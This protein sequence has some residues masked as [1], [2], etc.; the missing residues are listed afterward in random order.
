MVNGP[1]VL[2]ATLLLLV[3]T[4][5]VSSAS[6]GAATYTYSYDAAGN[7]T[8]VQVCGTGSLAT[9][10]NNCGTCGNKCPAGQPCRAGV[11]VCVP[12]GSCAGVCGSISDGCGG[13]L[14]CSCAA[15]QTCN[16]GTCQL[17]CRPGT[18]DKCG[19]GFCYTAKQ[20]C[21]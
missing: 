8:R 6:D 1:K 3:A 14:S 16:N 2:A 10:A 15:D 12:S 18:Y 11:C 13:T 19:D 17:V 21:N 7:M 4:V 20:A 5:S 9:D